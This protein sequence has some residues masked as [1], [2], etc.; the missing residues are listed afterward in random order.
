[1]IPNSSSAPNSATQANFLADFNG[2]IKK[3]RSKSSWL[4]WYYDEESGYIH[5]T[6]DNNP[7]N[8]RL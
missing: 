6:Y 3:I 2:A 7:Q 5:R 8:L 4:A 1:M